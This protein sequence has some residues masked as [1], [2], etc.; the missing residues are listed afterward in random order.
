MG[1][2]KCAITLLCLVALASSQFAPILPVTVIGTVPIKEA[3]NGLSMFVDKPNDYLWLLTT[4]NLYLMNL[5]S[6]VVLP[7]TY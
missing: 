7:F 6:F 1:F 2:T 5:T 3:I 4:G